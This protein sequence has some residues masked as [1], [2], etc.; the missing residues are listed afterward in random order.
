MLTTWRQRERRDGIVL[1][2]ISFPVPAAEPRRPRRAVRAGDHAAHEGHPRLP[3]H[4]PDRPDLP[5]EADLPA[6]RASAGI[7]AIVDG[8]HAFAH[9]PF[10]HADL[11]CDYYGTSLHKWLFAPHGT[12]FLYVRRS[13]IGKVWPLMAAR[14][15]AG[16]GHPQVRGDRHPP[17]GQPQR[18]RG[19]ARL[20]PRHRGRAQGRAPA[21]P[22]RPLDEAARRPAPREDPHELRPRDVLRHR[23][24]ADRGRRHRRSSASTSSTRAASSWCPSSTPSSRAC[25]SRPASTRPPTRS[26]CFA[27]AMEQVIAKG[28][29]A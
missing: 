20:P 11:D 25:A 10:T 12:G 28:L 13:K 22:A 14:E 4:E 5:G 27:E 2:T 18:D 24:R 9:F 1:K 16:R 19:G 26:T 6:W 8:A 17:R 23:Q 21:L 3:H 29:P 7:E 15:E